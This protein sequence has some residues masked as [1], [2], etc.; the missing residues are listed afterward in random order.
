MKFEPKPENNFESFLETYFARC[1]EKAP[2]IEVI[3]GK[4]R[5]EDLIPGM[6]DFDTRFICKDGMSDEDWCRMSMAVGSVHL[7]MC[8][9]Q[10]ELARIL[11]HLPG[12]NPTW[13]ELT[14]E[15]FYYPEYRQWTLYRSVNPPMVEQAQRILDQR[16]WGDKD[17]FFY[18]NKFLTYYGPYHRGI[19]PP[20]NLGKYEN[21]YPLHSRAMHYFTPPVQAAVALLEKRPLR[22]KLEALREAKRLF[23]NIKVFDQIFSLLECHYE[24]PE[25]YEDPM[26]LTFEQELQEALTQI[27]GKIRPAITCVP[28]AEKMEAPQIKSALRQVPVSPLMALFS[29]SKFCRLFKGRMYFYVNA[30]EHFDNIWLIQNELRRVGDMFYRTPFRIYWKTVHNEELQDVD[31][32][33]KRMRVKGLLDQQRT[34]AVLAFSRLAPGTWEPGTEIETA[35]AIT[36]VFDDLF[37]ALNT[38]KRDLTRI[39]LEREGGEQK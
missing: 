17:E 11:E 18:L 16:E 28:N 10:P 25:L 36:D 5:F 22:G 20:I 26:L 13:E 30:P 34:D 8:C 4:W 35:R 1:R 21:K 39:V 29:S 9:E 23:P 15:P 7:Q 33:T 31:E 3:A 6:S 14:Q 19:D 27:W 24:R 12:V 37:I 32:I 38:V 2:W